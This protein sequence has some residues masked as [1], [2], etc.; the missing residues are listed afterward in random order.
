MFFYSE[1]PLKFPFA[2]A[3]GICGEAGR[4]DVRKGTTERKGQCVISKMVKI[5]AIFGIRAGL[6][7]IIITFNQASIPSSQAPKR[8]DGKEYKRSSE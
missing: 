5:K 1:T 4:E 6:E 2:L 3:T 8:E 7:S